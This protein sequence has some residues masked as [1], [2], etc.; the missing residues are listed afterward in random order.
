MADVIISGEEGQD[1][2]PA[3]QAAHQAAVAEG[4]TAVQAATAEEAAGEAKAAAEVA[5]AAAAA[6]IESGAAV[7]QAAEQ[8]SVS[9][10][11]AGVNAEMVYQAIQAQTGAIQ[12]LVAELQASRKAAQPPQEKRSSPPSPDREPSSGQ[13]WVRR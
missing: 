7:E 11:T 13:R 4:A 3:E 10:A 9:A 5:L 8:A 6:N 2:T 12:E 1:V